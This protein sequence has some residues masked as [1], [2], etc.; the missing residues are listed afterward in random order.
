[1]F[2]HNNSFVLKK[3]SLKVGGLL[4]HVVDCIV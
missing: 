2:L 3:L 4:K 1:M